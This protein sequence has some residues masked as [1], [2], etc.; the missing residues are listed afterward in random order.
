[1][2]DFLEQVARAAPGIERINMRGMACRGLNNA[3]S[4]MMRLRVLSLRTGNTLTPTVLAT[5]SS[6]PLLAELELHAGHI[7]VGEF[8]AALPRQQHA[9]PFFPSLQKLHVRGHTHL[10]EF[11][12]GHLII[13]TL[14]TL[15]IEAEGFEATAWEIIFTSLASKATHTLEAL[16]IEHHIEIDDDTPSSRRRHLTI[17]TLAPLAPLYNLRLFTINMSFPPDLCDTDMARLVTWWPMIE[18]L[19]LGYI[20]PILECALHGDWYPRATL[21]SLVSFSRCCSRLISLTLPLHVGD[22]DFDSN[23]GVDTGTEK[24]VMQRL[25]IGSRERPDD[26]LMPRYLGRLFPRLSKVQGT[27]SHEREWE[28]VETALLEMRQHGL[29]SCAF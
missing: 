12:L 7:K 27:A 13:G 29:E 25:S 26:A 19:D 24:A 1:V 18:Y 16:T 14:H 8:E 20:E 9:W 22:F 17:D 3:L 11:I 10:I 5:I 2:S 23:L 21:A 28:K 15:R 6:L 4:S